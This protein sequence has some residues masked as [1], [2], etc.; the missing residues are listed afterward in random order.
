MV[1]LYQNR[2]RL[3]NKVTAFDPLSL[4]PAL[5]LKA[6][7]GTFQTSGG[8]AATADTDPVGEWQDQSGNANHV[9][10]ATAGR[11]P[12]LKTGIFGALPSVRFDGVDDYL[13]A[14]A[15]GAAL[16]QPNTIYVV[17]RNV[18]ITGEVAQPLV[19]G[20][21]GRHQIS[22][23]TSGGGTAYLYAGGFCNA[24][25]DYGGASIYIACAQA[26]GASSKIYFDGGAPK[27]TGNAGAQSLDRLV[28]W[29]DTVAG[30]ALYTDG[31]AAEIL[32]FNALHTTSEMDQ[33]GDYLER[34]GGTWSPSS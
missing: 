9:V 34:W 27:G 19:D 14:V 6:D 12:L 33:V 1:P 13:A 30:G 17:Y 32:V 7:A 3:R 25:T 22:A 26:N 16:A 21:A 20:Q 24:D 23:G 11:R 15:F 28:V 31:D 5:W 4:S 2:A 29:T 8:S 18:T 10:Q